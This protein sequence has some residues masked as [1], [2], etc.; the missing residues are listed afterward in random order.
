MEIRVRRAEAVDLDG[1]EELY[2]RAGDAEEDRLDGSRWKRG[3]YPLRQDAQEGLE[4]G[5][6]HIA[7]LDGQIAGSVILR[8]EQDS[9]CRQASWQI[10]FEAP[11]FVVH[12][13]AVDPAYRHRGVGRHCSAM[14]QKWAGKRGCRPSAWMSMRRTALQSGSMRPAGITAADASIWGWRKSM[15]SSGT[16]PMKSCSEAGFFAE[17]F[18]KWL[19]SG[20]GLC[21]YI[22]AYYDRRGQNGVC[23]V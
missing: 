1:I 12:T 8:R 17:N 14:P 16:T 15:A 3:V 5:A 7:E 11:V 6:L 22:T 21:Y 2:G 20:N 13:L 10:P 18:E 4:A 9:A 23:G 19:A